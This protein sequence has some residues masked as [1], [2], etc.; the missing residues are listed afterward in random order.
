MLVSSVPSAMGQVKGG[1]LRPLAVTS[2][3]RS[4]SLPDVP[5]VA[6]LGYKGFDVSSWYG[7]LVPAG[8][9]AH[10]VTTLNTEVN[11]LLANPEVR[12]AIKAQ[13]AEPEA[14]TPANFAS[15]LKADYVKW[16]D[17][18]EASGAKID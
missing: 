12:A 13:G 2:A 9:P 7:L 11:K 5:I 17:I 16:K 8:T 18:V 14:M 1:K 10:L 3:K 4:S 6:E 15:M